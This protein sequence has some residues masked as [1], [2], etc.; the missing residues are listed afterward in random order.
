MRCCKRVRSSCRLCG[1]RQR[2]N[3][4]VGSNLLV[5]S[6]QKVVE[7]VQYGTTLAAQQSN[8]FN[9]NA[10]AVFQAPPA[11]K[12][13]VSPRFSFPW[14]YQLPVQQYTV[15]NNLAL[16]S[17]AAHTTIYPMA[18]QGLNLGLQDVAALI[19]CIDKAASSGMQVRTFLADYEHSR[20]GEVATNDDKRR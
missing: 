6:V 3:L 16:I 5:Y 10:G 8:L 9:D 20:H 11:T 15:G 2:H 13:I 18:G 4:L 19:K 7:T 17:D 1:F 12:M 14:S